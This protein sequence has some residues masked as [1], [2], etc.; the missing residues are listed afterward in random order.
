MSSQRNILDAAAEQVAEVGLRRTTLTDVARRAGV[1]RMTVYREYGDADTLFRAL[2]TREITDLVA[3][4]DEDVA[5]LTTARAR[6]VHAAGLIV[7]RMSTHT[8]FRRVLEL[9]PELLLPLV[10]DR[11]GSGQRLGMAKIAAAIEDG[12]TD[13]SIRPLK[14]DVASYAIQLAV[15]SFLW[16]A[17]ITERESDPSSVVA[18]LRAMLDRYLSP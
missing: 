6:L 7:E 17:R 11:L 15:Q 4:V 3:G 8:V 13:G 5:G 18:E 2:L 10:V 14:A 16:S 9:D 1:S 12:N